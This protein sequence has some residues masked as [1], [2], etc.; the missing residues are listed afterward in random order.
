MEYIQ[1]SNAWELVIILDETSS[2]FLPF[3]IGIRHI[4]VFF[5]QPGNQD[6]ANIVKNLTS[7]R[8]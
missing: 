7:K 4:Y 1:R 2:F 6:S 8:F 3:F 5:M